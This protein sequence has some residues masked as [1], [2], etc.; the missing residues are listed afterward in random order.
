VGGVIARSEMT[1]QSDTEFIP[2]PSLSVILSVAKN[3][4]AL[5]RINSAKNLIEILRGLPSE[6]AL[7]ESKG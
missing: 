4:I 6:L 1:K 5:L 3:L 7:S 2:K